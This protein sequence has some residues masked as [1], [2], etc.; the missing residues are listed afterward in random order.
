[1]ISTTS[2]ATELRK[3]I[4]EGLIRLASA[5]EEQRGAEEV[6]K[7]LDTMARF[8]TYSWR[9]ALLV[10]A[11]RPQ[12]SLVAGFTHWKRLGREVRKGEKAIRIISPCPARKATSEKEDKVRVFF[13]AA[14]VFD[15][16]QTEGKDLPTAKVP[17]IHTNAERLL[18]AL[19]NVATERGIIVRYRPMEEG[20]FG[21]SKGGEVEIATGHATGQQSKSLI[22]EIVHE[23][24][25]QRSGRGD[26][27]GVGRR[28]AELEAEA[29]AYV[30]CRNFGL[31]VEL[32]ASRYIAL[33]GEDGKAIAA[34]LGRISGAAR[35]LIEDV[36]EVDK[37]HTGGPAT[38]VNTQLPCHQQDVSTMSPG[39]STDAIL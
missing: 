19:G 12:A 31:D 24:I 37:S 15:V 13:K 3:S 32:R 21:V 18:T 11:Q 10:S 5:V 39:I 38:T 23:A 16:S 33:W 22:H 1:M 6:R 8:P 29:V 4:D 20:T 26:A 2:L 25:H 17:E 14:C 30:V 36:G 9:N 7:Y 28:T 34:S 27:Y 35:Q